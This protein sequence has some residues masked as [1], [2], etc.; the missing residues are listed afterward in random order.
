[1]LCFLTN[2]PGYLLSRVPCR[3]GEETVGPPAS[4]APPPLRASLRKSSAWA[5]ASAIRLDGHEARELASLQ[6][7]GLLPGTHSPFC[8]RGRGHPHSWPGDP[9][10]FSA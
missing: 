1:M 10:S 5:S 8:G 2:L 3:S 4:R 9:S 6:N 7:V